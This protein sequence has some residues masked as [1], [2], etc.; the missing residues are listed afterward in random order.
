MADLGG[1][2]V[3]KRLYPTAP[4]LSGLP[5]GL[6]ADDAVLVGG[7]IGHSANGVYVVKSGAWEKLTLNTSTR[8]H[9][10]V[11]G[12]GDSVAE[13]AYTLYC[14]DMSALRYKVMR[15]WIG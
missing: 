9:I 5:E 7:P 8:Y 1:Y 12:A 15:G 2:K 10:L 4:A 3:A 13:G 14:S 6:S 11:D